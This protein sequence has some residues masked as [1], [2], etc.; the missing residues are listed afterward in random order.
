VAA[1]GLG[2]RI[3]EGGAQA[4]SRQPRPARA[5]V[6]LIRDAAATDDRG[7]VNAAVVESMLDRGLLALTGKKDRA[8]AWRQFVSGKDRVGIKSNLMMTPTH[9]ELLRAICRGLKAAGVLDANILTWDRNQCG[10]G[11]REVESLPRRLGYGRQDVSHGVWQSTALINVPGLK[12]H[13]LAGVACAL[14]NW[15]GAVTGINTVDEDVTYAF[16][17]DSCREVGMLNAIPAI[18][19]RCRLVVVDALRPLFHGGP[20]VDP[21]YL[22]DYKGLLLSTDPVAV[23]TIGLAIIEGKRR[24]FRGGAWP[25]Q[26]PVKHIAVADSDYGLGTSD[27][28]RVDLVRI[29]LEKDSFV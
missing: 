9:P 10:R 6:V 12:S 14:K 22:W 15:A 23:D 13:W 18:R 24:Q 25:L 4:A 19:E 28:G 11:E 5:R 7:N 29:G 3:A 21:R 8:S 16:H 20:Q 26:P 1:L 17:A 2:G 27:R